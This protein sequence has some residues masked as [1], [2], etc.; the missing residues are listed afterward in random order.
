MSGKILPTCLSGFGPLPD[1]VGF[2]LQLISELIELVEIDSRPKSK[3]VGDCPRRRAVAGICML[4]EAHAQR[5]VH[6]LIERQSK[7]TCASLQQN[8]Q[9][10]IYGKC[11][12]HEGTI[13]ARI[14]GVKASSATS[15]RGS[16]AAM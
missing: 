2:G 1:R 16:R 14:F 15:C 8:H 9:I 11:G 10:I 4:A 12:A 5:A 3:E 6:N 13:G 7:L